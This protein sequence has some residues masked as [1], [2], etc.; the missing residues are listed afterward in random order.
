MEKKPLSSQFALQGPRLFHLSTENGRAQSAANGHQSFLP[1]WTYYLPAKASYLKSSISEQYEN[2]RIGLKKF[3]NGLNKIKLLIS[4]KIIILM[5]KLT[6]IIVIIIK[7]LMKL[8]IKNEQLRFFHDRSKLWYNGLLL[9]LTPKNGKTSKTAGSFL[10]QID[11]YYLKKIWK[12]PYSLVATRRL[13]QLS[14]GTEWK[15]IHSV[16]R[17][18]NPA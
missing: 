4:I 18:N 11:F 8:I 5:T 13:I 14:G 6:I 7:L 3:K 17:F 9:F 15:Q 10:V 1:K 12:L 16:F 2:L